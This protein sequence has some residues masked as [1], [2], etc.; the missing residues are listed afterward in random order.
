[1]FRFWKGDLVAVCMKKQKARAVH[2]LC[3][4]GISCADDRL[5][6]CFV[7]ENSVGPERL[8]GHP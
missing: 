6:S 8:I 7:W 5:N 3:A 4:V 1:M 2:L